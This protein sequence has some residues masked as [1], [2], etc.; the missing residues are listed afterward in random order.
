MQVMLRE[1]VALFNL[2]RGIRQHTLKSKDLKHEL[3]DMNN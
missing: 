2:I 1:Q 3:Q